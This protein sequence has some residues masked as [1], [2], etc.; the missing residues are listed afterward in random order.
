MITVMVGIQT[1]RAVVSSQ[2]SVISY[3]TRLTARLLALFAALA[4]L[5]VTVVFLFSIQTLHRGIDNWFD[6]KIEQALDDAL[7]LGRTALDALKQDLVKTA[8]EMSVELESIP[9]SP[10][11]TGCS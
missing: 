8:Q 4:V 6:V 2:S 9:P 3:G 1:P 11:G 5:P 10:A 7:L